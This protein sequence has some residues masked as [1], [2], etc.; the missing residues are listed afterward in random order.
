MPRTILY[1]LTEVLLASTGKFRFYGIAR[2]VAEIGFGLRRIDPAV[3][4]GVWVRGH[5]VFHE[6]HPRDLEDG[7][8]DPGVPTGIRQLRLRRHHPTV[9][10]LRDGILAAARPVAAA[11]NRRRWDVA[12]A[13]L[14]PVSLD[15]VLLSSAARPKLIA[16]FVHA[17]RGRDLRHAHLLHDMMPLHD[18]MAK[19]G[20]FAGTFLEDNR[21]V[22]AASDL[23]IANSAFTASEIAR[24]AEAGVLPD[25]PPVVPVPLVHECPP[26]EG[27]V[28]TPP[29]D[30]PYLLAV[31]AATGR[32]NLEA[33]FDA[34]LLLAERGGPVPLLVLAGARRKRTEDH[35][36]AARYDPIRDRVVTRASPPQSD[37]VALYRGA[38]A[39]VIA[40]RMEGWGLPAGEALWLGTPAL[41]ADVPALREVGR[42]LALYFDPDDPAALADHVSRLMLDEAFAG[43]LRARI[44][45]A[46]GSLRTWADVA[47]EY[48][49]ALE[50]VV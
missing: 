49:D 50:R 47:R 20:S 34:M 30:E 3:Q 28:E 4:F 40:S 9:N 8:I 19:K 15:N 5:D 32:K 39:L 45:A 48:R 26:G 11:I 10:P 29:P 2:T 16:E 22:V 38:V 13:G 7:T 36:G 37:L 46:H 43:A 18:R 35:L 44:E 23:L 17:G 42:D 12:G 31:G 25:P 6:V 1:D 21:R 33:A 41:C 24:F 14:D 27:P